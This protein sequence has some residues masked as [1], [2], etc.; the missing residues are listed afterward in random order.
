MTAGA[1]FCLIVLFVLGCLI[2]KAA[3]QKR[4]CGKEQEGRKR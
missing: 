1:L 3:K 2:W 4:H